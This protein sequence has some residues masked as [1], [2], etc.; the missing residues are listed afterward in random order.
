MWKR[1]GHHFQ[2]MEFV[3]SE[4]FQ[5]VAGVEQTGGNTVVETDL[6]SHQ[7]VVFNG[8]GRRDSR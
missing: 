2:E 3:E 1:N 8:S 4:L 7:P 5:G 6:K